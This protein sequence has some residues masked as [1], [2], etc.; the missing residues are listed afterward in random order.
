MRNNR[1]DDRPSSSDCVFPRKREEVGSQPL[2]CGKVLNHA[3]LPTS[4]NVR[5]DL[6]LK[7]LYRTIRSDVQK[8]TID[9]A[10]RS[11]AVSVAGTYDPYLG[12][13]L[14]SFPPER[15]SSVRHDA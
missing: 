13:D 12:R 2:M 8:K 11:P 6:M 10:S 7:S 5:P 15:E 14:T 4:G 3:A 1:T 9:P